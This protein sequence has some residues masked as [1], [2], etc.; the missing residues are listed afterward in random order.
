MIYM[1]YVLNDLTVSM[2]QTI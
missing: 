2:F 1:K